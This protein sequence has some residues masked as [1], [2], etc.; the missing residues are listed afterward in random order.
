LPAP[1]FGTFSHS[2][3]LVGAKAF[4]PPQGLELDFILSQKSRP[5]SLY[6]VDDNFIGNR[7]ATRGMLPHLAAW[8]FWRMAWQA[9]RRGQIESL[10]GVGFIAYHLIEFSREE[11]RGQQNASLYS[12]RALARPARKQMPTRSRGRPA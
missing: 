11:L 4:M 10:F 2:F 3:R 7:K 6:F 5:G 9:I 1:A 12:A 8:P